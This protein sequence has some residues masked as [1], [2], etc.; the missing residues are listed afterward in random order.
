MSEI[1]NL[2]TLCRGCHSDGCFKK[3]NLPYHSE[4]SVEIYETMLREA[5][6][7]EVSEFYI[8]VTK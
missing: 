5:L 6:G 3:L 4:N 1:F 7:I 2:S 8:N